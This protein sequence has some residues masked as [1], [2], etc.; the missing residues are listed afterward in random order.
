MSQQTARRP[1]KS[2]N[3][4]ARRKAMRR[5]K[6]M[7]RKFLLLGMLLATILIIVLIIVGIVNLIKGRFADTTTLKIESDGV[8]VMDEVSD[9][10]QSNYDIDEL[11]ES[12]E[13]LVDEYNDS[14]RGGKVTFKKAKVKDKTAYLRMQYSDYNAYVNFTG[15]ELF[16]GTVGEAKVKGYDF[17]DTFS[18]VKDKEKSEAVS[19]EDMMSDDS[20]KVVMVRGNENVVVPGK[21]TAVSDSCTSIV[22]KDEIK[23]TQ[24]DGNEDATVLTVIMYE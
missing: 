21:I 12:T 14:G 9:F 5:K 2:A 6:I 7:R 1:V 10:D 22:D 8:V 15:N 4:D 24:P 16:V 23:I 17:A 20:K 3:L 19:Q 18:T 13:K 11:E